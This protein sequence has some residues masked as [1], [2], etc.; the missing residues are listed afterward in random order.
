MVVNGID[1]FCDDNFGI[2]CVVFKGILENFME[3][4]CLK[5]EC[6]MCGDKVFFED[7]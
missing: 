7:Y 3:N 5:F 2:F 6:R 1:L 4:I